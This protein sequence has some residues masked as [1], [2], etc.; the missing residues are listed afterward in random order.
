MIIICI[1]GKYLAATIPA[2]VGAL[3]VVQ[4]YYLRTSRQVRLMDIE[5]KAPIYKH[6]IE[7]VQGVASIR[8]FRW[9]PAFH[10]HNSEILN[11]S[12]KPF[13]MLF[14]VQQWLA[15]VLDLIV[16][17]LAVVIIAMATSLT[18]SISAGGLGVSLVLVLQFNALLTQS[19]QAWTKLETSIGAV[20]RVQ[21]FLQ[22]TPS[23]PNGALP[24]SADWPPR[25][26]IQFHKLSASYGYVP[27]HL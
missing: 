26:A 20:A 16:G 4:R 3:F 22:D 10:E 6:F 9:G 12:Q 21:R 14:C 5:A 1:L 24:P 19:V 13:Y 7:T 15:L 23:E 8:A 27:C 17:A 2:L 18:G 25:G 11:Q